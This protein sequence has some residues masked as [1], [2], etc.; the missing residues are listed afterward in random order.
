MAPTDSQSVNL[1]VLGPVA[2]T[3]GDSGSLIPM[4]TQPRRLA[5]LAYLV[6]ARPRGLHSRDTLVAMLSPES[7]QAAGRH[8]LRNVLHAIRRSLGDGVIVTAGDGMVG[9]DSGLVHCDAIELGQDL[10]AGRVDEAIAR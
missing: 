8:A 4:L 9:A 10:E 5:V 1:Q 3:G 2:V 7:D 6:L